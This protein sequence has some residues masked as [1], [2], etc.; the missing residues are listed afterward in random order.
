VFN[1]SAAR[2]N[3]PIRVVSHAQHK[4][5]PREYTRKKF[6]PSSTAGFIHLIPIEDWPGICHT[7]KTPAEIVEYLA[8]PIRT[9]GKIKFQIALSAI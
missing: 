1:V 2:T 4:L 5:L 7:L 8:F 3:K 6:H 9:F